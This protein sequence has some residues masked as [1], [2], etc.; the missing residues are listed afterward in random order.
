MGFIATRAFNPENRN[1]MRGKKSNNR[2]KVE[3]VTM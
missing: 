3:P 1:P 2:S